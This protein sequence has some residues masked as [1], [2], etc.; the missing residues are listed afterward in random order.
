VGACYIPPRIQEPVVPVLTSDILIQGIR[1][2][3]VMEWLGEATNQ[4]RILEAAFDRVQQTGEGTWEVSFTAGPLPR[5]MGYELLGTDDAHGGRRVR[6]QTTGKRT[7]GAL[8]F[9]LRS[10]KPGGNTMVTL[11][12]DYKAG[13]FL[14]PMLD[15]AVAR[16][17]L[18]ASWQRV[19]ENLQREIGTDLRES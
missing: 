18:Q 17:A 3:P 8:T 4:A 1:R 13:R 7:A 19:L 16:E 6:C 11:H 10:V 14:G 5:S 2:D 15:M 12:H 9:S